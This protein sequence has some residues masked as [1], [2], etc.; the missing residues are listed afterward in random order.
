MPEK[1]QA[2]ATPPA[3]TGGFDSKA[4]GAELLGSF[5]SHLAE[6]V[7]PLQEEI[8]TLKGGGKAKPAEAEVKPLSADD[9]VRLLDARDSKLSALAARQEFIS[10]KMSKLPAAYQAKLGNDPA[11]W[12]VEEQ[13]IREEFRADLK[14]MGVKVP[15]LG[16]E[17]TEETVLSPA[18]AV[19]LSKM[20]A[21]QK[22]G[23]GL[24]KSRPARGPSLATTAK[25]G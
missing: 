1:E 7:K 12:P 11:K 2:T 14:S 20:T 13:V 5:K 23:I 19:D 6:V 17:G 21:S 25:A 9:V 16:G 10:K 8:N 15:D 3:A 24:S 18:A 4:F 22:I